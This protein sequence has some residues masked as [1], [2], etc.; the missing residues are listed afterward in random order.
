MTTMVAMLA[1]KM[2]L[3]YIWNVNLLRGR[4][5]HE[6]YVHLQGFRQMAEQCTLYYQYRYSTFCH[7]MIL[8]TTTTKDKLNSIRQNYIHPI[9]SLNSG[10]K[11]SWNDVIHSDGPHT[12]VFGFHLT[13]M[14]R[15]KSCAIVPVF[16][17]RKNT[18]CHVLA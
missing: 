18:S 6:K 3:P 16:K 8:K 12:G 9:I 14:Y 11:D 7:W 10:I 2:K 4:W 1:S 5:A 15:D 17:N 13:S